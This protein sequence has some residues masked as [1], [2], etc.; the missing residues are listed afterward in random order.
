[1]L[2]GVCA[3]VLLFLAACGTDKPDDLHWEIQDFS[4]IDQNGQTVSL[5][6]LKGT[7]WLADF[8]FTNCTSVCQPM[9][10]NMSK[11]Q[12]M[13]KEEGVEAK[14]VSFTVDPERDTPEVLKAFVSKFTED[15]SNWH[16]LTGY[17]Q[18]EISA[19]ARDS[20][21]TIAEKPMDGSDQFVHQTLFYLVDQNG[22]I[23]KAYNGTEV[24][25]KEV[26]KDVK[27]LAG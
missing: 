7:V 20:F 25:F 16:L 9:T 8:I 22:V 10:H 4:F 17:T 21:K 6:S 3:L 13:L 1:M 14:I 18:E 5:E 11:I 19:F 24:D 12:E 26:V 23:V 2:A 27:A 15:Q